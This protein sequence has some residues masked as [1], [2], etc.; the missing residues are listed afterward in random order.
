[1]NFV[2]KIKDKQLHVFHHCLLVYFAIDPGKLKIAYSTR[3]LQVNISTRIL[4][5]V[6]T[7]CIKI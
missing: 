3:D 7:V 4:C 2:D 5:R 6:K 1:M